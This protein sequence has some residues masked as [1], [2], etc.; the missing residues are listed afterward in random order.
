MHLDGWTVDTTFRDLRG[1]SST[2]RSGAIR[3]VLAAAD[4][5]RLTAP[6]GQLPPVVTTLVDA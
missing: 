2:D 3:A 5:Y 4:C 6:K 1:A